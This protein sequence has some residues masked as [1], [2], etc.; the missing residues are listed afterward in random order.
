M[1]AAFEAESALVA[2]GG[3]ASKSLRVG[4]VSEALQWAGLEGYGSAGGHS[5]TEKAAGRLI[6]VGRLQQD[7][8]VGHKEMGKRCF[9]SC[10]LLSRV[11][12]EQYA[13]PLYDESTYTWK[14]PHTHSSSPGG[15]GM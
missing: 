14:C 12:W 7:V 5:A 6:D 4:G 1:S 13:I 15:V 9:R 11:G 3:L 2:E 8:V 10:L